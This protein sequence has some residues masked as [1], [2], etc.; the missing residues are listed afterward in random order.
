MIDLS[1]IIPSYNSARTIETCIR[2]VFRSG[3]DSVEVIVVD[4]ASTDN[5][6]E[7]VL[8]LIPQWPNRLHLIRQ[9]INGGP[10]VARNRGAKE[11]QAESLFFLDSDTKMLDDTLDNFRS[12]LRNADAVVGIYHYAP[13]NEG[14]IPLYKALFNYFFFNRLGVIP[15]E[16][17]DSSRAGIKRDVFETIGGFNESLQWGMDYENEE[18][19]YRICD[20]FKQLLDPSVA[21]HHEFPGFTKMTA[22][23]FKRVALW[24]EIFLRRRRFESGGVTSAGTGISSASLLASALALFIFALPVSDAV[25]AVAISAAGLLFLLYLWGFAGFFAFAAQKHPMLLI[26]IILCNIFFTA[27][28]AAAATFGLFRFI[29]GRSNVGSNFS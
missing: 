13:L 21:V 5:S 18:L 28:T 20:K 9:A 1:V 11:A 15:Y 8:N 29:I 19:G 6:P 17:F 25:S 24:F 16:V 27:V 23:Y 14:I 3:G 7:L 12:R 2:S 10:A 4:D 22:I 26:P